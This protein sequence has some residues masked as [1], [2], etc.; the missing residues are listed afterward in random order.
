MSFGPDR[1]AEPQR[2]RSRTGRRHSH[3]R[4]TVLRAVEAQ[5][6]P[7]PVAQIA[8]ATSLHENT[9]RGHLEQLLADGHLTR[10]RAAADGRGR[11]AWLWRPA[12]YGPASPYAALAGALAGAVARTSAEPAT[13][14]REA[15]RSWG[16]RI[17]EDLPGRAPE[18]S[19]R[20]RVLQ[21]MADQGFAPADAEDPGASGT[22]ALRRC[23]LLDAAR[24]NP[25]VVCAV[26]QGM[27]DALLE[28]SEETAGP[29]TEAGTVAELQPF[30]APGTCL[31]HL[32]ERE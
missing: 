10:S 17:A 31:L 25:D 9:V 5:H 19:D 1:A 14:A 2:R 4:E 6:A 16:R 22:I 3:A 27:L 24:R 32:R 18:V 30:A 11:P 7:V 12:R 21:A 23:P 29:G 8:R 28:G 15:G 26:H 20:D 13:A